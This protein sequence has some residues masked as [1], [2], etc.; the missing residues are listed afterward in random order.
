[1]T[2]KQTYIR[3]FNYCLVLQI[4]PLQHITCYCSF[5]QYFRINL[6]QYKPRKYS[7]VDQTSGN[8]HYNLQGSEIQKT[9]K[10]T[11]NKNRLWPYVKKMVHAERFFSLRSEA[12]TLTEEFPQNLNGQ[13]Q[14]YTIC[15]NYD[16]VQQIKQHKM[17]RIGI[18]MINM[19][20]TEPPICVKTEAIFI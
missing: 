16:N 5:A 6:F 10:S 8:V 3:N 18:I 7:A 1:M 20:N 13:A 19:L 12:Y 17:K 14:N 2:Y 9:S 4:R 15:E 11:L